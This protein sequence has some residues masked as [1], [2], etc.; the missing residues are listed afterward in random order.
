MC[1][2]VRATSATSITGSGAISPLAWRAP[3]CIRSVMSVAALPM[4]ICPTAMSYGR[5]SRDS[6]LVSPVSACLVAV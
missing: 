3:V 6:A 5:P 4:S 1:R 2:T